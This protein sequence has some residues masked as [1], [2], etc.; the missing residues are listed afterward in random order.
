VMGGQREAY[1]GKQ[2]AAPTTT[3]ASFLP[4]GSQA[5]AV[6]PDGRGDGLT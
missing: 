6:L 1:V 3:K 5:K 2:R 4:S